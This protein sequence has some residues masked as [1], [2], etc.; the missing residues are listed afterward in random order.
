MI[1]FL[2]REDKFMLSDPDYISFSY[3]YSPGREESYQI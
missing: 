2:K 1:F 3:S